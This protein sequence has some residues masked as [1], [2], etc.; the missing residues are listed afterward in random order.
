M[1][2]VSP[3]MALEIAMTIIIVV[4]VVIPNNN[5]TYLKSE[6]LELAHQVIALVVVQMVIVLRRNESMLERIK[7]LFLVAVVIVMK[8]NQKVLKVIQLGI[9]LWVMMGLYLVPM[10][11]MH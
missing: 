4:V 8:K 5:V 10:K 9:C 7:A 1:V 2:T 11:I 3:V 6:N